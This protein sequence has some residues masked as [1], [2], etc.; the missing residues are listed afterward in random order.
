MLTLSEEDSE[1]ITKYVDMISMHCRLISDLLRRSSAA[2]AR[3]QSAH[4]DAFNSAID[5]IGA[6]ADALSGSFQHARSSAAYSPNPPTVSSSVAAA[7]PIEAESSLH[8]VV[9]RKRGRPRKSDAYVFSHYDAA[10]AAFKPAFP[11][12]DTTT[13]NVD[14]QADLIVTPPTKRR[15]RP[16]RD[17]GTELAPTFALYV[18]EQYP[19]AEKHLAR[20]KLQRDLATRGIS[21]PDIDDTS[22]L[23]SP[24]VHAK[25]VISYLWNKW[26][27]LPQVQ[28]DHYL[29]RTRTEIRAHPEA[30]QSLVTRFPVPPE[31]LLQV[32]SVAMSSSQSA[33]SQLPL[34]SPT[35]TSPYAQQQHQQQQQQQKHTRPIKPNPPASSSQTGTSTP[36]PALDAY[37][38]FCREQAPR[39]RSQFPD[40]T[41]EDIDRRLATQWKC[42]EDEER[43]KY[44]EKSLTISRRSTGSGVL[45]GDMAPIQWT[46]ARGGSR[47]AYVIFCRYNRNSISKE[48]PDWE[49]PDINKELG[50]R[51]KDLPSKEKE[52]YYRLERIESG[53]YTSEDLRGGAL[54]SA[55]SSPSL[56]PSDIK[57]AEALQQKVQGM[58]QDANAREADTVE[59]PQSGTSHSSTPSAR[60]PSRAY[61]L[62]SRLNRSEVS[63]R[64]QDN[65]LAT[66]NRELNRI[67]NEMSPEE[68]S[69][70]EER[71][72]ATPKSGPNFTVI[73]DAA[74]DSRQQ[75]QKET[76]PSSMSAE[77]HQPAMEGRGTSGNDN[78][79]TTA[80]LGSPTYDDGEV[81]D[82]DIDDDGNSLPSP[83]RGRT[84]TFAAGA[85]NGGGSGGEISSHS[86]KVSNS[87]NRDA[88]PKTPQSFHPRSTNGNSNTY[89]TKNYTTDDL[90]TPPLTTSSSTFIGAPTSSSKQK[91]TIAT[92]ELS[93][94]GNE[95]DQDQVASLSKFG[96]Q[97]E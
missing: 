16:P 27:H 20:Q 83:S 94:N 18:D 85:R 40:W 12:A 19:N 44:E 73:G 41:E 86:A 30:M 47:R 92:T 10:S 15:G 66:V 53:T 36:L 63:K 22:H 96:T 26:W 71:A 76:T 1:L 57:S 25:E 24:S 38:L 55:S 11:A 58:E 81:E 77:A 64:L 21:L 60:G 74:K 42:M 3:P 62:F 72:A 6:A 34:G 35:G 90:P 17:L 61:I 23:E 37:T 28:K 46:K 65:D 84:A 13:N 70:W 33:R 59:T 93:R 91:R 2:E 9:P 75:Q 45:P 82:V 97:S 31:A 89:P 14:P 5:S 48:H 56:L 54:N 67:W 7:P 49:L 4:G 88:N 79:N 52:E 51:W 87:P 50:R 39:V 80:K 69:M 78:K 95:A 29:H 43:K 68:R 32:Q 8:T